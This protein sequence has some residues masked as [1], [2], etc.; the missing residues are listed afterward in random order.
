MTTCLRMLR[1]SERALSN[2]GFDPSVIFHLREDQLLLVEDRQLA[3]CTI[4]TDPKLPQT[5]F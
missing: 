4:Q 3:L 1:R 5:T 2:Q